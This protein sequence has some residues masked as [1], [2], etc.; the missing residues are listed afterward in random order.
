[1]PIDPKKFKKIVINH[2]DNLS[3]EEFLETLHK[4]SPY[5]F[6]GSSEEKRD[7]QLSGN[8][9]IQLATIIEN[10]KSHATP[11]KY[12]HKQ[13]PLV[14]NKKYWNILIIFGGIVAPLFV[15]LVIENMSINWNN[16][17]MATPV[18]TSKQRFQC[19]IKN[20]SAILSFEVGN[21]NRS[22]VEFVDTK[23]NRAYSKMNRCKMVINNI[24]KYIDKTNIATITTGV[25]NGRSII[26]VSEKNGAGCVK[27]KYN[28]EIISLGF[29][30]TEDRQE[31]FDSF[32]SAFRNQ[33]S[34]RILIDRN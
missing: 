23:E 9:E 14:K 7:A 12:I 33:M 24:N 10:H 8:D 1:M 11:V 20:E 26:C 34:G 27:D 6:D 25:V 3:E 18:F 16:S 19:K 2:F 30:S 28:G 21:L 31:K 5:L 13:K 29:S 17:L 15:S 4:S 32:T 22:L